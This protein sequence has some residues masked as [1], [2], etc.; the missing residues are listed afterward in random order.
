MIIKHMASG[1]SPSDLHLVAIIVGIRTLCKEFEYV[2][3]FHI[4]HD[5]NGSID[6]RGNRASQRLARVLFIKLANYDQ[7]IP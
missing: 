5:H 7:S 6:E 2:E 4:F 3:W 1:T